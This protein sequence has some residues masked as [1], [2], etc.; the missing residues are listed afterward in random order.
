M[1]YAV[2]IV[3]VV[4][5]LVLLALAAVQLRRVVA[6]VRG[7]APGESRVT[8]LEEA[9]VGVFRSRA[10]ASLIATE[11]AALALAIGG[12]FRRAPEGYSMHRGTSYLA[13]IG[14]IVFL[15][16][17]EGVGA[18]LLLARASTIAAWVVSGLTA[19]S[20][21]WLIGDA[22]AVRLSPLRVTDTELVIVKGL[23]WRVAVPRDAIEAVHA[24]EARV[25]GALDLSLGEPNVLL[26]LRAP[27]RAHGLLGRVRAADRVMLSIDDRERFLAASRG[28]S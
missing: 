22:Q 23:R 9:L 18:H 21:L 17:V 14:V 8:A 13:I 1:R 16:T 12:W 24:I 20:L 7:R 10:L 2:P 5:D 6:R 15:A 25:E 3:A 26:E 11:L 28:R 4:V 19:Y 27:V